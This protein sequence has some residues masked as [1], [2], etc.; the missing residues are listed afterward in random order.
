MVGPHVQLEAVLGLGAGRC[1]WGQE[2]GGGFFA[3]AQRNRRSSRTGGTGRWLLCSVPGIRTGSARTRPER[4]WTVPRFDVRAWWKRAHPQ[5][6]TTTTHNHHPATATT[7]NHH[8]HHPATASHHPPVPTPDGE[9]A[10]V[11]H[12]QVQRP[13]R[14]LLL[15][16]RREGTHRVQRGKIQ[17]PHL[18]GRGGV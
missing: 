10:G 13:L 6:P 14:V 4:K 2:R 9:H 1:G 15:P 16:G 8:N 17:Q 18:K 7:H 3:R 5:P 12:Q 11:V